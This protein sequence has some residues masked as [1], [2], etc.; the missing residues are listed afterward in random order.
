MIMDSDINS[1]HPLFSRGYVSPGRSN[2]SRQ[3]EDLP[4]PGS[5]AAELHHVP[6]SPYV[7]RVYHAKLDGMLR[8]SLY[9]Y[10]DTNDKL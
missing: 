1:E 7:P 5:D 10:I 3:D 8:C 9:H 2:F 6:N 4:A